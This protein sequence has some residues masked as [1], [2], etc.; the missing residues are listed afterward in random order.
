MKKTEINFKVELDDQNVPEKIWWQATDGSP[1]YSETKTV[2]INLWDQEKQNTLRIDLWSK[3]LRIDE[4][5]K[6]YV[7]ILGGMSQSVLTAT[8]DSII[9]N[10]LKILC[11]ELVVHIEKELKEGKRST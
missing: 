3:D 2:S 4:M 7:D 8:G 10:K 6:F 11:D 5:K 1:E 9:S